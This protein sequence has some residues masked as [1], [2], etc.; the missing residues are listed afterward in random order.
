M[1]PE[2]KLKSGIILSKIN[3]SL[4]LFIDTYSF[5][6]KNR[7]SDSFSKWNFISQSKKN[8]ENLEPKITEKLNKKLNEKTKEINNQIKS[9]ENAN[10]I[11]KKK[12]NE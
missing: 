2:E 6:H 3:N 5:Y 10:N 7:L 9:K 8:L 1:S 4:K 12:I 11:L